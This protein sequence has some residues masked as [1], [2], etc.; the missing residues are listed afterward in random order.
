MGF[1]TK[2]RGAG[3]KVIPLKDD[4][5]AV[6][7]S[8]AIPTMTIENLAQLLLDIMDL[9]DKETYVQY[10]L[11][12][13]LKDDKDYYSEMSELY[14]EQNVDDLADA[15]IEGMDD[16]AFLELALKFKVNELYS[17]KSYYKL[18]LARFNRRKR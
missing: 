6:R 9:S 10:R 8:K 5:L 13:A 15:I 14:D 18:A 4:S 7:R 12:I 17:D 2:G 1:I 11:T 16:K 3:R